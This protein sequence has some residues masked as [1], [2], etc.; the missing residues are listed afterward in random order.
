VPLPD[1]QTFQQALAALKAGNLN[2]AE[3][4]FKTVLR[5]S[6]AHIATLNLL[7][8][9][10]TQLGHFAEAETYLRLALRE[11]PKSDATLY[12]YGS[13]L[14]ALNRPEEALERF[15]EALAIN[16]AAPET[17]NNRGT[18]LNEL[19][20]HERAL[21]DFDRAIALN[22]RFAEA[23][24]NKGKSL[25]MLKRFEE[26]LADYQRALALQPDFAEAWLGRGKIFNELKQYADALD[27]YDRA[28]S[29]KA[30]LA[31]AWLGRG[32][33]FTDLKRHDDA[34]AAYDK[35]LALKPGLAEAWLGRGNVFNDF[36]QFNEA[37]AA[38]DKALALEPRLNYAASA[39]LHA[40]LYLCD[41]SN[42]D[43][44]IDD[45]L[46]LMRTQNV[47][48]IPFALLSISSSP[49]DQL[50]CARGHVHDQP[51]FP[52]LWRG[53]IYSH[54]RIRV[55]Y[56]SADFHEHPIANSAI[57]LYERHDRSRFDA[58][59]ISFGPDRNSPMRERIKGAFE[60]F[61]DVAHKTD[62]EIAHLVRELEIDI[63][64]DLMGHTE[65]ARPGILARRPAPIQVSYLGFL[66]TMGAAYIDYV[67]ANEI[68]LPPEQ[69]RYYTESIVHLPGCFLP[70]DNRLKIAPVT[71]SRP[72]AGLPSTGFVFCSFNATY[73]FSPAMFELWMRLLHKVE[74]SV[75]WL[76]ESNAEAAVNLRREAQRCGIDP[77]RLV[78]APRITLSAHLAR[79]RLADLFL[80]TTPYNAGATAAASLWSGVP[81]LTAIG[82]TF[83]GRMAASI[84]HAVG[85]AELVTESLPDY[86]ALALKIAAEPAYRA[87][88]KD[89]LARNRGAYP[90]FDTARSTRH[91][92]AAYISMWQARQNGDLPAGFAVK[93]AD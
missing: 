49:A 2:E 47:L 53:E 15:T 63:A 72:D 10:L 19:K 37:F 33:V 89:K 13:V 55:A 61:I 7:G 92:E 17:W 14:K 69:Q 11:Q 90:L 4:L 83:V 8:I 87:A 3:R 27:A 86:E 91:I 50:L 85:L 30:G 75:L 84:L 81:V 48:S 46:S 34:L 60:H 26:A 35:A 43:A 24:Y 40:K 42:L 62:Q 71:P 31:E 54:D 65:N 41:W 57:G 28:L 66:G 67:I 78:F 32:N 20:R 5:A 23:F 12:N 29:L 80:D 58:T 22:P 16:P 64:V 21:E 59:A 82:E 44:E 70:N 88:L 77:G 93:A 76:L 38:Y 25:T 56:L 39:R 73:K 36:K 68:V 79:Q 52:A 51:A 45:L 9:T 18:V 1:N 6:P 74:G